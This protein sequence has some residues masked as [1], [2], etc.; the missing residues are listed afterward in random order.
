M[1]PLSLTD[2]ISVL[3]DLGLMPVITIAA[4]IAIGTLLYKR[5]RK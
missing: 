5:F 1:D 2:A 4:T 3:T